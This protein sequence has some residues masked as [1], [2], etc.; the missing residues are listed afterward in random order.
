M[1]KRA[2]T[3]L[4]REQATR[5]YDR[6]VEQG[7]VL[8]HFHDGE[9][10][11]TQPLATNTAAKRNQFQK[12]F[13]A[14]KKPGFAFTRPNGTGRNPDVFEIRC[15]VTKG[16]SKWINSNDVV[17]ETNQGDIRKIFDLKLYERG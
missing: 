5:L 1:T 15:D 16:P 12:F 14:H 7:F 6:A 2:D 11:A 13:A 9:E 4:I 3:Q 8:Y 10:W 17:A